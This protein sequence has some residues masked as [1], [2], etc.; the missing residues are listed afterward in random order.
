MIKP[1]PDAG[2][3]NVVDMIDEALINNVQKYVVLKA[4][5]EEVQYLSKEGF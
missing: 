4:L 1:G 5:P 3:G 2:Y